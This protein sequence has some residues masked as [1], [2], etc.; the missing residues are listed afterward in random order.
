MPQQDRFNPSFAE[1]N[2]QSR[3][4]RG[5]EEERSV[6]ES[7][8]VPTEYASFPAS[9]TLRL[10]G[11][12]TNRMTSG[13]ATASLRWLDEVA[14]SPTTLEAHYTPWHATINNWVAEMPEERPLTQRELAN[15][16][17]IDSFKN[18]GKPIDF[19]IPKGGPA[20]H[21]SFMETTHII[22]TLRVIWNHSRKS[23]IGPVRVYNF[24]RRVYTPWYI[25]QVT[26]A[27]MVELRRR[28]EETPHIY[29]QGCADVLH[30]NWMDRRLISSSGLLGDN[31]AV[32]ESNRA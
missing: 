28:A 32:R 19:W 16:K 11:T 10:A 31:N 15:I 26:A 13:S 4:A 17:Y 22:S 1:R 9:E 27:L 23:R 20:I 29:T 5:L 8:R 2:R 25:A 7:Y 30:A 3:V 21:I 14:T 12:T 24:E 6:F 18:A